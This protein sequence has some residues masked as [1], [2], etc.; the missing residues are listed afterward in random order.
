MAYWLTE[1]HNNPTPA[2]P[3]FE[4]KFPSYD[5]Y[6]KLCRGEPLKAGEWP[7]IIK[8][9][10]GH[11]TL[12]DFFSVQ[13]GIWGVAEH[14]RDVL[15]K[16]APSDFEFY[17]FRAENVRGWTLKG[18]YYFMNVISHRDS[19]VWERSTVKRHRSRAE[20]GG[21]MVVNLDVDYSETAVVLDHTKI[22]GSDA[23][24]EEML[25]STANQLIFVSDRLCGII[26]AAELEPIRMNKVREI[27]HH[28]TPAEA[29]K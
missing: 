9:E 16:A 3:R 23:W 6:L 13:S 17:P 22:G 29:R 5:S 18:R 27:Y 21:N 14:A 11:T 1:P 10:T 25:G 20:L 12:P 7:E 19:V 24:H 8:V 26:V 2:M 4:S 15:L 28:G